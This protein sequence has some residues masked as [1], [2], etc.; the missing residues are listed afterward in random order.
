LYA[1]IRLKRKSE[2]EVAE[3]KAELA[4]KSIELE[5]RWANKTEEELKQIIANADQ[6]SDFAVA[7]AQRILNRK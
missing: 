7:A 6:Y 2:E 4:D 3:E 1:W 5:V